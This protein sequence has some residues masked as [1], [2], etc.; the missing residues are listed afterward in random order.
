MTMVKDINWKAVSAECFGCIALEFLGGGA[1]LASAAS[2][3]L[4][5]A[6][7]GVGLS[8][9]VLTWSELPLSLRAESLV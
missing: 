4:L 7:L 8:L 5:A 6:A 9:A 3:S 2:G 1:V